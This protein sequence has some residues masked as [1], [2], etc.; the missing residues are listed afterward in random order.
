[1]SGVVDRL[2]EVEGRRPGWP[3]AGGEDVL[4]EDLGQLDEGGQGRA[5]ARPLLQSEEGDST[6][7]PLSPLH[8][9]TPFVDVKL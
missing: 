8:G 1:M 4:S 2:R 9:D 5:G 6:G 3:G 7:R